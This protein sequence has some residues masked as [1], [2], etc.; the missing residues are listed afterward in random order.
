MTEFDLI[1]QGGR[2]ATAADVTI[3]DIGI[4]NGRIAALAE[5]LD[6]ADEVINASGSTVTPGG[7]DGHCHLDQPSLDGSVCA[8]DFTSGTRSAVAGGTTTVIPFALQLRGHSLKEAIEDY[9][10]RSDGKALVDYAFHLIVT[11]ASQQ[12]C[13]QELPALLQDGYSSFKIYMTYDDLKLDDGQILDVL[14]VARRHQ[15]MVMIHAENSECITWLTGKLEQAGKLAPKYHATS[16]PRPVEREATHRAITL[17]EL[18]DV[19]VLIVH[20]SARE[21]VQEIQRAQARGLKVFGETCPQYMFLTEDDLDKPGFEGAKCICSP[22]PRDKENQQVIWDGIANGTFQVI[23]SDHSPSRYEDPQGKML[24]GA[25]ASFRVVP[26]GIPGIETR[27]PL[28]FSEG[29]GKGRI[30]LQTFVALTATNAARI[31]GLYPRKGTIAIGSDA[32]IVIWDDLRE[33]TITND[34]LHHNVDYTPYEG[35]QVTG[36]PRTVLSRG[37]VVVQ[38]G[39]G[40]GKA[41]HGIFLPCAPPEKAVPLGRPVTDFQPT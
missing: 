14:S 6:R 5:S 8:D 11:D 36:W 16:R 25:D 19:P 1:I 22:P 18:L 23:S 24:Q 21:A 3:C 10:R 9:H 31:Y 38:N 27:M 17:A 29:V 26:N 39:E 35:I 32:D 34:M 13:G 28:L 15:G 12:V 2:V 41:G 30:D 33:V 7:V 20:V 40:V 37:K 4:K